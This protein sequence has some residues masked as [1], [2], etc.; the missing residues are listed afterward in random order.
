MIFS[1][2]CRMW[3][4]SLWPPMICSFLLRR[5]I[6]VNIN[7]NSSVFVALIV[8]VLYQQSRRKLKSLFCPKEDWSAQ[9]SRQTD[10]SPAEGWGPLAAAERFGA[11]VRSPG[12]E[13]DLQ[14]ARDSGP[15]PRFHGAQALCSISRRERLCQSN[16]PEVPCGNKRE[17]MRRAEA[18]RLLLQTSRNANVLTD[19]RNDLFVSLFLQK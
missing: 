1:Q 13:H 9:I 3:L 7:V 18:S 6:N 10:R 14:V 12:E 4:E 15:S 16:D 11:A 17:T 5:F 2:P 8:F 19:A